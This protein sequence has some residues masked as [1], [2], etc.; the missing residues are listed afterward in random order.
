MAPGDLS[1]RGVTDISLFLNKIYDI[2]EKLRHSSCLKWE[3]QRGGFV[4]FCCSLHQ[5]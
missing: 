5:M 2:Y 4:L 1:R 3:Q